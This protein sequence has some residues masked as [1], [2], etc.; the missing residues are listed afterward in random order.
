MGELDTELRKIR[1][2]GYKTCSLHL[3]DT[4]SFFQLENYLSQ[5]DFDLLQPIDTW[6]YQM[7]IKLGIIDAKMT[8]EKLAAKR[9]II[10]EAAKTAGVSPIEF[11]QGLWYLPTHAVDLLLKEY[12]IN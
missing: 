2:V 7:A 1:Q 3:R 4:V 8:L 11:N 6:V 5:P 9:H 12:S 10:T